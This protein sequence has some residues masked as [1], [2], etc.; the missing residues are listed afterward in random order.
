MYCNYSKDKFGK[1]LTFIIPSWLD[2]P[3]GTAYWHD[4]I[5][6]RIQRSDNPEDF[7][8]IKSGLFGPLQDDLAQKATSF[9]D[10]LDSCTRTYF[11]LINMKCKPQEARQVL[12]NALKTEIVMTGFAS[13]WRE[14]FDKRLFEKTGRVHPMML[15]LSTEAK[16]LLFE[17]DLWG[18]IMSFP[19]KFD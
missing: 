17:A 5:C 11:K 14:F 9:L 6:Y 4:G 18:Y 12:P 13:D 1:E 2:I 3:E 15:K 7:L 8:S 19:S 16:Q 10:C